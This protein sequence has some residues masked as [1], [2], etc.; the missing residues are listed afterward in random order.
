[1]ALGTNQELLP[2]I[3]PMHDHQELSNTA[4]GA[5]Y[6]QG[7]VTHF[8]I[9]GAPS[10]ADAVIQVDRAEVRV[11]TGEL[12]VSGRASFADGTQLGIHAGTDGLGPTV[13]RATVA[14]GAFDFRGRALEALASR[15]ITIHEHVTGVEI[16]AIPLTLR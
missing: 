15:R 9:H 16:A 3:F 11:K 6:P 13:G 10:P 8:E 7:C 14:G 4:A 5:N 12:R 1:V 2:L